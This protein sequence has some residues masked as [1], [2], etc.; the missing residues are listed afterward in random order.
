MRKIL[1]AIVIGILFGLLTHIAEKYL[2]AEFSFL[3]ETKI[4]WLL[5]AFLIAFNLPLRRQKSDTMVV[6]TVTLLTTGITYYL[7]EVIKNHE[8][9]YFTEDLIKFLIIGLIAGIATGVVA[10]LGRSATNSFIRYGSASLLPAIFTGDGIENIIKTF[11]HFEFTPE[12]IIKVI[13]GIAFYILIAG[14]NKFKKKSL[15]AF[16]VLAI[17]STLVYLYMV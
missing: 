3:T 6:A 1:E 2:P 5:P 15:L 16:S 17:I 14:Q 12:I 4:I 7:S 10:Y 8:T 13:G 11:E 9:F